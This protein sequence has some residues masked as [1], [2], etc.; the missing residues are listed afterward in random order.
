[1]EYNLKPLHDRVLVKIDKEEN[2]TP[3]GIYLPNQEERPQTGKVLAVGSG[4]VTPEGKVLPIQIKVGD[5]VFFGKY[6]GAE[7]DTNH[8]IFRE[9]EI[10]GIIEI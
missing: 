6:T 8:M 7:A 9:E 5:T 2:K 4:K 10:L 1:M 3:A